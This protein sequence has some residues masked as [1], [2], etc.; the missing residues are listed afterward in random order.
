[1]NTDTSAAAPLLPVND[2]TQIPDTKVMALS[3]MSDAASPIR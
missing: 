1:M 3:P 2:L